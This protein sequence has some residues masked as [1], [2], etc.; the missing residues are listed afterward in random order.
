MCQVHP[1]GGRRRIGDEGEGTG[2]GR[3]DAIGNAIAPAHVAPT[4]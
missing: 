1:Q 4:K 3:R 2:D